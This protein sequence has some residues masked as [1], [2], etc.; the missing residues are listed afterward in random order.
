MLLKEA[1]VTRVV[2]N[3]HHLPDRVED[4]FRS[5]GCFGMDV[6]FSRE[7]VILGTGGGLANCRRELDGEPFVYM[8]SDIIADLD[9]RELVSA[10]DPARATGV[11]AVRSAAAGAGRVAVSGG[12]VVNLRNMLPG[13]PPPGH[14]FLGIAVFS[15]AVFDR[16]PEGYSDIVETALVP[17]ARD[18]RASL[19]R[20]WRH[21]ARHRHD[22]VVS[23]RERRAARHGYGIRGPGEGLD[24]IRTECCFSGR[25]DR[26][27]RDDDALGHR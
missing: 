22:R 10:L 18:G 5:R 4:F 20:I 11:L 2:C 15:P 21:V 6:T 7:P 24:G 26:V 25:P 19:Q 12:H 27:R 9:V 14:D 8:N 3:L 16:L 23:N 13:T 1:G 17:L